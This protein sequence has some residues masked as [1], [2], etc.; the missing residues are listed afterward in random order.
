MVREI[1]YHKTNAQSFTKDEWIEILN[2]E[3]GFT[4]ILLEAI[5]TLVFAMD[6]KGAA[7][8]IA[9]ITGRTYRVYNASLGT[10][11]KR[12]RNVGYFFVKDLREDKTERYW[13]HF[14]NGYYDG[15]FF[16][17]EVKDALY[18]AMLT[19]VKDSVEVSI[20]DANDELETIETGVVEGERI[21]RVHTLLER[22]GPIVHIAKADF[23][24]KHGSLF[25][26]ACG[27]SFQQIYGIEF[28]EAHHILPL[29]QGKR[30]TKGIDF[31]MLCANC[32]RAIHSKKWREK[33]IDAF[34]EYM[35]GSK[36]SV[37]LF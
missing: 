18:Q 14:F 33:S 32:H 21:Q 4:S 36:D 9:H 31:M 15:R 23:V 20:S 8:E 3:K 5:Y 26:E 16:I 10:T 34:L 13:S 25:C 17:W 2:E 28:I 30:K 7:S 24:K 1:E 27:F 6:G 29:Y 37:K 19:Y 12:L 22:N 11:V 35:Q